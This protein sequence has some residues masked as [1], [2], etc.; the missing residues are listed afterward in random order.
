MKCDRVKKEDLNKN[1]YVKV[2]FVGEA[3]VDQG[4]LHLCLLGKKEMVKSLH[5]I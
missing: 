4:G 3:G 1:S 2:Q 5:I